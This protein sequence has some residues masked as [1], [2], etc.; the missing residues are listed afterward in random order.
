MKIL[1][2]MNNL[3]IEKNGEIKNKLVG[4]VDYSEAEK[5][6]SAIAPIP[7]GVGTMIIACLFRNTT[8]AYKNNLHK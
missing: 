7:G 4:D 2:I 6:A 8:I 3:T 5:I 1:K